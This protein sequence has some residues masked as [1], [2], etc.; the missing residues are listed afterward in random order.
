MARN[1]A[2]GQSN[3]FLSAGRL[4]DV[5]NQYD[6]LGVAI[7]SSG[8]ATL[9]FAPNEEWGQGMPPFAIEVEAVDYFAVSDGVGRGRV[10]DVDELGYKR[11]NDHDLDWLMDE[12]AATD[13]DHLVISFG[14]KDYLRIHGQRMLL[15][16]A[17]PRD[18]PFTEEDPV[19]E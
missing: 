6:F 17:A 7:A 2:V 10:R 13:E 19:P 5:H 1:F 9:W 8:H 3:E 16:E 4:Y 12:G 14:P 18:P 15:R 11:P